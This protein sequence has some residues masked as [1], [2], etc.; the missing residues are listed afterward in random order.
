M[1]IMG[2]KVIPVFQE[3]NDHHQPHKYQGLQLMMVII[4]QTVNCQPPTV[5]RFSIRHF[6]VFSFHS[7][8]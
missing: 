1:I 4:E 6:I 8:V 3:I 5:N 7:A 2:C